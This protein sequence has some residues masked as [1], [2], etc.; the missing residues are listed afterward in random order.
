MNNRLN[1]KISHKIIFPL[2]KK[3]REI[4]Y[5]YNNR[6]NHCHIKFIMDDNDIIN[7]INTKKPKDDRGSDKKMFCPNIG[8][9][10]E[11]Q[12]ENSCGTLIPSFSNNKCYEA[13]FA[14]ISNQIHNDLIKSCWLDNPIGGFAFLEDPDSESIT[15]IDSDGNTMLYS[16]DRGKCQFFAI[17]EYRYR[18]PW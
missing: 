8:F 7:F 12:G 4:I 18:F 3:I 10:F 9:M 1:D 13:K 11:N 16:T 5:Y 6:N 2:P 17:F 15:P 14:T